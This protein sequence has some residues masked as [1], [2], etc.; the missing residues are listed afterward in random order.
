MYADAAAV[1]EKGVKLDPNSG[2]LYLLQG[3]ILKRLQ[4]REGA[5]KALKRAKEYPTD[6]HLRYS[7][8]INFNIFDSVV[9]YLRS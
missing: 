1:V 2:S 9:E 7:I 3:I 6:P 5:R 8:T 4:N